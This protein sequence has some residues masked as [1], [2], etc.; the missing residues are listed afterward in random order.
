LRNS[1]E[2]AI[3]VNDTEP[4][5][6]GCASDEEIRD[7]RSVPHAVVVSQIPLEIVGAL[8]QVRRCG[9]DLEGVAQVGFEGVIVL[10]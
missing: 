6:Q 10:G 2:V 7:R 9:D 4:V 1:L 5:V 3:D 8:E